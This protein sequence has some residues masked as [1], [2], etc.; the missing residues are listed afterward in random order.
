MVLAGLRD[1]LIGRR[2]SNFEA[3]T[4]DQLQELLSRRFPSVD[5]ERFAQLWSEIAN[6]CGVD[7]LV[8]H[9]DDEIQRLCPSNGA[10]DMNLKMMELEALVMAQSKHLEPPVR[11]PQTIGDIID[12]LLANDVAS[13]E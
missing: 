7:P 1:W 2:R 12:Y 13:S 5:R 8:M 9:E 4:A 3:V 6:I 11:R 10:L